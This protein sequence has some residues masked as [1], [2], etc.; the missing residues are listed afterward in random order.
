M[1]GRYFKSVAETTPTEFWINNATP[2][3]ASQA[4]ELGAVGATTNP[5]YLARIVRNDGEALAQLDA[6][7]ERNDGL[8]EVIMQAYSW[9]VLR[10]QKRFLPLYKRSQG[11]YGLVA[12]Q[13]N[14][15]RNNDADFIIDEGLRLAALA[16]NIILKVPSTEAGAAA[17]EV[18]VRH[19]IPM[20]ATLGFSVSQAIFMA[21]A[22]QRASQHSGK[23][24]LCYVTYIAGLLDEGLA[25][26]AKRHNLP[27]DQATLRAAGCEGTRIAYSE[28]GKRNFKA[29]LMGGGARGSH[30]FAELVGGDLAVTIGWDLAEALKDEVPEKRIDKHASS[31]TIE[32]LRAHLPDFRKATEPDALAPGEFPDFGPVRAFQSSFL[33]AFDELEAQIATR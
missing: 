21:E 16:E 28:Y 3:Q 1:K 14:P 26:E 13:G 7:V 2:E 25:A 23:T 19:D 27:L 9:S 8:E 4:L 32:A 24:P 29:R 15:R 12:I 18:L 30:H 10:L 17:M 33:K 20:I 5:T 31:E 22:Y 6:A 11:R